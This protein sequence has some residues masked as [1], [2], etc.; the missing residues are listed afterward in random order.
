MSGPDAWP[1]YACQVGGQRAFVTYDPAY[2]GIARGD[3]RPFLLKIRAAF[4]LPNADGLPTRGEFEALADLERRLAE[5]IAARGG[6]YV[7]RISLGGFRYFHGFV[8]FPEEEAGALVDEVAPHVRYRL[9]SLHARDEDKKGYFE[10]LFPTPDD[11]QVIRDLAQLDALRKRGDPAEA[12]REVRHR[13]VFPGPT[14]AE[15]FA[16]WARGEGYAVDPAE[17]AAPAEVRFR[18][19]GTMVLEDLTRHT[20]L[21]G[22]KARELGGSYGGWETTVER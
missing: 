15:A 14:A 5:A 2:A 22:R 1:T 12:V 17:A 18:H 11:E 7:G 6:A 19:Q 9:A 20:I 16:A 13:A 21:A 8:A 10:D 3:G 4:R